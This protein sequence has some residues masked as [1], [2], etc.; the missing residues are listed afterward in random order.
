MSKLAEEFKKIADKIYEE[1]MKVSGEILKEATEDLEI[2]SIVPALELTK[3]VN[4][5][6]FQTLLGERPTGSQWGLEMTEDIL[7][8]FRFYDITSLLSEEVTQ[9]GCFYLQADLMEHNP[10]PAL[11]FQH[12]TLLPD[13]LDSNL[14]IRTQEGRHGLELVCDELKGE[15]VN[16][17]SLIIGPGMDEDKQPVDGLMI[18]TVYPGQ[19]TAALPKD[20]D[21]NI[22]SLSKD[23]PYAV[24]GLG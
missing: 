21:G 20:W 14:P 13:A 6:H 11:P 22:D 19:F 23:L 2:L 3:S 10:L 18:Y 7:R 5:T 24:K 9:P 4:P 12:M 1:D 17:V 15:P 16:E 8:E